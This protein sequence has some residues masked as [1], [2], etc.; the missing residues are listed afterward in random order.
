MISKS[1][2][3]I[4]D[5]A[6]DYKSGMTIQDPADDYIHWPLIPHKT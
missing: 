6:D 3:T 1:G 4:E 2:M 5:P